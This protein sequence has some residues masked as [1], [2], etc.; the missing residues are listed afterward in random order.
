MT[1]V[2]YY[3]YPNL[4]PISACSQLETNIGILFSPFIRLW[5]SSSVSSLIVQNPF[6]TSISMASSDAQEPTILEPVPAI[7]DYLA[8]PNAVLGDTDVKWRYGRA[9]DYSK[10]RK[11]W[12]ECKLCSPFIEQFCFPSS[13]Y[14]VCPYVNRG[15]LFQLRRSF[16]TLMLGG[17]VSSFRNRYPLTAGHKI[18]RS[19]RSATLQLTLHIMY[20]DVM[21]VQSRC[22]ACQS[23]SVDSVIHTWLTLSTYSQTNEP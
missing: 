13:N 21:V 10:T 23:T 8:S 16:S 9:P 18:R 6:S 12:A 17:S 5:K 14:G 7:P 1:F 15:L 19:L 22:F 11:V 4:L 3:I 2:S 20:T